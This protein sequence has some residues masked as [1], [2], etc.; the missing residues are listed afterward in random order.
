VGRGYA[1]LTATSVTQRQFAVADHFLTEGIAWCDEH[2]IPGYTLYLL[3]WRAR[4]EVDLG[5]WTSAAGLVIE[6]MSDPGASVPQQ[7]VARV[8]GGLLAIR[9][10]DDERGRQLLDEALAQ[11]RPTGEL[12]RLAPVSAARA[13]AAWLR[14]DPASIDAETA[15]ATGLAAER[16]QPWELGELAVWRARAGLTPPAGVVAPPFAAELAGDPV[17]AARLWDELNCPYEAALARVQADD[18]PRLRDALTELQRL[19]AL[20]AA[21]LVSRR[22]RELGVRDIPRG[23]HPATTANPGALTPRELEVLE[24]LAQGLRNV[25]IAERLVLSSRTVDHHVSS[26]LGK[27]GARTRG[28]ASAEARRL[29]LVEDR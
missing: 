13:E 23:P 12:Q 7:I 2:D 20:P 26:I 3:A 8:A 14:R 15:V 21:R 27:L 9:T 4:L 19:G 5:H 6:V 24:L 18:E 1:N 16:E 28:E 29:G 17:G 25:E 11:A 10:G 22:L